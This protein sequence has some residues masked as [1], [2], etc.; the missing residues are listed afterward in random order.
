VATDPRSDAINRYYRLGEYA[1]KVGA[2]DP[3]QVAAGLAP[4]ASGTYNTGP[5]TTAAP[6]PAPAAPA[7]AAPAPTP[8]DWSSY[9]GLYGLPADV[10]K[11]L[12]A[13]F[14]RTPDVTQATALALAYVRGTPWYSQTYPG[15]QEALAKGIVR[16]EADYRFQ[17]NDWNQ[18]TRQWTGNDLS[19]GEFADYLRQGVSK[20]TVAKRFEGAA[21]ATTYGN[22]WQYE[23]GAFGTGRLDAGQLK[24]LGEQ[25][26]GLQSNEGIGLQKMI[27][28]AKKKLSR[29]FDGVLATGPLQGLGGEQQRAQSPDIGR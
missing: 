1:P 11:E 23:A 22:D 26:A 10:Q 21:L 9:L 20:D 13:I 27:E 28:D 15:I 5:N 17:F 16:N 19:S 14:T 7:P 12:N 3:W 29:V 4:T 2:P 24:T 8:V 25:S 6:A 18:M